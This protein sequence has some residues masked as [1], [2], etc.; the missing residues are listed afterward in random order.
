MGEVDLH[1]DNFLSLVNVRAGLRAY[2]MTRDFLERAGLPNPEDAQGHKPKEFF[3]GPNVLRIYWSGVS[4]SVVDRQTNPWM[5]ARAKIKRDPRAANAP[6]F[7]ACDIRDEAILS[8]LLE[9]DLAGSA[10]L[11]IVPGIE[12]AGASEADTAK[13]AADLKTRKIDFHDP[14]PEFMGRIG[15]GGDSETVITNRRA[16]IPMKRYD[17]AAGREG[18][19]Q[20]K[21]FGA[22]RAAF[23]K[24][25]DSASAQ[26][27][28]RVFAYCRENAALP[29]G[30][31]EKI[32][33]PYW[34]EA[35]IRSERVKNIALAAK[36]FAQRLNAA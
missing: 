31:P 3:E 28:Q 22:L 35:E 8:P 33:H 36:T 23:A 30:H 21:T 7:N 19:V 10:R 13:I 17:Y 6:V 11:E 16:F 5:L 24:A 27:L 32:L 25:H 4:I 20:T 12:R 34:D 9:I 14:R 15:S 18:A 1:T 26:E 29:K 2:H